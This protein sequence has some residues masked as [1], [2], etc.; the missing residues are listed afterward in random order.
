LRTVY[1]RVGGDPA[2]LAP[3]VQREVKAVGPN[4]GIYDVKRLADRVDE[5]RSQDRLLAFMSA[6]TGVLSLLLT[7]IGIYGLLAYE[8]GRRTREFGIRMA[9]GATR[10]DVALMVLRET[11]ALGTTSVCF[12]VVMAWWL[13]SLFAAQLF[14]V[15][16][17]DPLTIG[18][19]TACIA[20]VLVIATWL[21]TL[22]GVRLSPLGALRHD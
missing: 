14:G 12:G 3:A 2:A 9:L 18:G 8:L 16:A 7:A 13:S 21:P 19:A 22:R 20:A 4:V 1:V 17:R 10:S 6:S 5:V 15:S 11:L